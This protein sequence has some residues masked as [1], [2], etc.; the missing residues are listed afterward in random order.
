L[1]IEFIFEEEKLSLLEA[2][3]ASAWFSQIQM[4]NWSF[5]V[6]TKTGMLNLSHIAITSPIDLP[7]NPFTI[8]S[9]IPSPNDLIAL[10][11]HSAR[12]VFL[13]DFDELKPGRRSIKPSIVRIF[14]ASL[15]IRL[16]CQ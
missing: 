4:P 10:S 9:G 5:S 1:L 3:T 13:L 7:L 16:A 11:T 8:T 15:R 14:L 2:V 12:S 6:P